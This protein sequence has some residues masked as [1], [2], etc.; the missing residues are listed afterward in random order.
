MV[1][2][3]I[4]VHFFPEETLT[5]PKSSDRREIALCNNRSLFGINTAARVSIGAGVSEELLFRFTGF[6]TF[7]AIFNLVETVFG[8]SLSTAFLWFPS[9][10]SLGAGLLMPAS[11]F[12]AFFVSNVLFAVIHNFDDKGKFS[13]KMLHKPLFAWI[14]GWIIT[15]AILQF[16]FLGAVA[17]HFLADFIL[18]SPLFAIRFNQIADQYWVD[19]YGPA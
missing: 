5:I 6:F 9:W 16:G 13:L 1:I 8:L 4:L 3:M 15:I 14:L 7:L 19:Q 10:I 12:A 18:F 2:N 17:I 11:A